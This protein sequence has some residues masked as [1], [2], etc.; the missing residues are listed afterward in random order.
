[1]LKE[2]E[3]GSGML[4]ELVLEL[5]G[6]WV[7]GCNLIAH[8]DQDA[9]AKSIPTVAGERALNIQLDIHLC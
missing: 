3:V 8:L 1:M 4:L 5:A 2:E 9:A 6:R 7:G